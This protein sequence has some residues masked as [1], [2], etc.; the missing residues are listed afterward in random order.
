M[1][2]DLRAVVLEL[3][4]LRLGFRPDHGRSAH[5][6]PLPVQDRLAQAWANELEAGELARSARLT[7][8]CLVAERR[9]KM[10][11]DAERLADVCR[12][13]AVPSVRTD[14]RPG[15]PEPELAGNGWP[16]S[17]HVR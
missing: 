11:D 7:A 5:L 8:D 14:V 12:R 16:R 13:T 17:A 3:A 1:L 2:A 6:L 4:A 10:G 9:A 15:R